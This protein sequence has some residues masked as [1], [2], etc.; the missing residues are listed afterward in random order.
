VNSNLE[1][2]NLFFEDTR[3]ALEEWER[4]CLKIQPGDAIQV[5]EPV[6]R[7]AHNIKGGAGLVGLQAVYDKMHLFEDHLVRLRDKA[8][9]LTPDVINSLLLLEKV[10]RHWIDQLKTNPTFVPDTS[11]VEA[12]LISAAAAAATATVTTSKAR[13]T[14]T[15]QAQAVATPN[16]MLK[17]KATAKALVTPKNPEEAA[18]SLP[19]EPVRTD[20][21]LRVAASKLDHLIQLVGEISLHQAI[22]ERASREG[23]LA[24]QTVRNVIDIK[25]KLTQDLQDAAL[26]L[27][28]IPIEGLFQKIERAV[29]ETAT[30]LR[31][32]VSVIRRGD[33]VTLDKLVVERMLDPLIHIAR[34]AMDH[35]IESAE[36]RIALG[37]R[38]NGLVRLAAENTTGGV[39]LIFEDDGQGIDPDIVYK[40][41]VEKGLVQAGVE[42]S[43]AAKQQLIFLPGLSTAHEVTDI[44]GR[45]VG[46]DVVA[47]AVTKMGGQIDLWSKVGEGTRFRISLPT[48]LSIVDA[49][50]VRVNGCQYAIP[51]QELS[52]VVNLGELTVLPVEA[53]A[54]SVFNLRGRVVP[55]EDMSAFLASYQRESS[56]DT[57]AEK[58]PSTRPGIVVQFRDELLAF[59]VDHVV[60]QQQIFV[61]PV[62]DSL[63]PV[64]VFGGSTILSDGEPS[65]ILNLTEMARQYFEAG[66]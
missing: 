5:L 22:L 66:S 37:K 2:L 65:L 64:K 52:E 30:H 35:G 32:V 38:P 49:L 59:S 27:R 61:R 58:R 57:R 26:S 36:T 9:P 43:D 24:S 21:T 13:I 11:Q 53:G 29:R 54:A 8:Q 17:P 60:G 41:A 50:V 6:F 20:E 28:M 46:M 55:L 25:A 62:I 42:M 48:N 16:A 12:E 44:S 31:K 10:L 40:K 39:T 19:G 45:G 1:L 4:V 7:C 3:D 34:N 47:D 51:N 14:P 63:A 18:P 15:P 33:D 56:A 23:T